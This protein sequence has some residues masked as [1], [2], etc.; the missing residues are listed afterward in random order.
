MTWGEAFGLALVSVSVTNL[1]RYFVKRWSERRM[2]R[3]VARFAEI[4]PGRCMI[5][6]YHYWGWTHGHEQLPFAPPH[7]CIETKRGAL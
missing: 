3:Y 6:S 7:E 2:A 4:F 5:C 1:A